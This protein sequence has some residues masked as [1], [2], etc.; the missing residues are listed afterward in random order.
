MVSEWFQ[1]ATR[2]YQRPAIMRW[3]GRWWW[4]AAMLLILSGGY[5]LND[6]RYL[7]VVFMLLMIVIPVGI[8]N[9]YFFNLLSPDLRRRL[10][11][12]QVEITPENIFIRYGTPPETPEGGEKEDPCVREKPVPCDE[13]ISRDMV[14]S[15]K[16]SGQLW[17]IRFKK[18]ARLRPDF[19]SVPRSAVGE[20][21]TYPLYYD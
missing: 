9:V 6:I 18:E 10:H 16:P 11:Y 8:F 19:I 13:A 12:Q 14:L 20:D 21:I 2:D 17:I 5:A 7:L 15:I 3:M 1:P 4:V